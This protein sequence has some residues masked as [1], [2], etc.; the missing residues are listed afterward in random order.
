ML[1]QLTQPKYFKYY[2]GY[3][4]PRLILDTQDKIWGVICLIISLSEMLGY[5][6]ILRI[7]ITEVLTLL[8][9]E[10]SIAYYGL[11]GS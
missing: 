2:R 1:V 10:M 9:F 8:T 7:S 3:E 11:V 4:Q 5:T 6:T